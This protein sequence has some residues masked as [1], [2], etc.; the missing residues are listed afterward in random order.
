[1]DS[2][3]LHARPRRLT[4]QWPKS[5]RGRNETTMTAQVNTT[6][7]LKQCNQCGAF[8]DISEFLKHPNCKDGRRPLCMTCNR[9]YHL[10]YYHRKLKASESYKTKHRTYQ[11]TYIQRRPEVGKAHQASRFISRAPR[12]EECGSS[13]QPLHKHHPDYS[14]PKQVITLCVPCHER[15]HHG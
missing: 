4:K 3:R 12:C 2:R 11:R 9:K 8:K 15:T 6:E 10:A 14:R 5:A 7:L 13:D 1:M